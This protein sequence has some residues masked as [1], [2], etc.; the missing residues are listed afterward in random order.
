MNPAQA[1]ASN[2]HWLCAAIFSTNKEIKFGFSRMRS[3]THAKA[4]IIESNDP[5]ILK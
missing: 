4:A 3:N 2:S 5:M 1:N